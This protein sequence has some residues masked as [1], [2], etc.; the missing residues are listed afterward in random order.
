MNS[1][2]EEINNKL[3]QEDV[4]RWKSYI[5]SLQ[6]IVSKIS[7]NFGLKAEI[8]FVNEDRLILT[9][10]K[11]V[12]VYDKKE[13][14]M[15]RTLD[16]K[17]IGFADTQGDNYTEIY[18][19]ANGDKVYLSNKNKKNLNDG[20]LMKL[21]KMNA[22]NHGQTIRIKERKIMKKELRELLR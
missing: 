12:F 5:P 4:E 11:G 18:A 21:L 13:H 20:G 6:E 8:L 14:K 15:Y 2:K 17:A 16:R 7:D 19:T 9:C 22:S 1:I 10:Y 3:N